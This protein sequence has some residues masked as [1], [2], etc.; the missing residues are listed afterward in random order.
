M[1]RSVQDVVWHLED[2]YDGV[3][4]PRLE[5]DLAWCK[6]EAAAFSEAYRGR[7]A[8]L[9]PEE[10]LA[11]IRRFEILQERS[12]KLLSFPIS[13]FDQTQESRASALWQA[14]LEFASLLHRDTLFFELE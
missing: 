12:R 4:D 9:S 7:V 13:F 3:E 10:L 6:Q 5:E 8:T 1:K 14:H 11:A 2:L